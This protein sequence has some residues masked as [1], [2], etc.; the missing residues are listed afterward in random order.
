M[1]SLLMRQDGYRVYKI[2][3]QWRAFL[4]KPPKWHKARGRAG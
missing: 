3:G 2:N 4:V 1:N